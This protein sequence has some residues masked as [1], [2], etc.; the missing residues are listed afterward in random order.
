VAGTRRD[1]GYWGTWDCIPAS[2][3]PPVPA[4]PL[5]PVRLLVLWKQ[6]IVDGAPQR[7]WLAYKNLTGINRRIQDATIHVRVMEGKEAGTNKDYFDLNML[8]GD[9]KPGAGDTNN[10]NV[11]R[12]KYLNKDE[13]TPPPGAFPTWPPFNLDNWTVDDDYYTVI[14]TPTLNPAFDSTTLTVTNGALR[15]Y[16]SGYLYQNQTTPLGDLGLIFS[17]N[18]LSGIETALV[19][20]KGKPETIGAGK[21]KTEAAATDIDIPSLYMAADD[22][23][24]RWLTDGPGGGIDIITDF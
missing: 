16:D 17:G 5:N 12:T 3:K 10:V 13:Y 14:K 23:A 15:I 21:D 9:S 2:I 19:D 22:F 11:V 4:D 18:F 8:F 20:D 1:D 24:V 6:S 7:T